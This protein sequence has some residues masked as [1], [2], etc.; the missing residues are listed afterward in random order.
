[1]K[2]FF[3]MLIV[4]M[5]IMIPVMADSYPHIYNVTLTSA[6]TEYSQTLPAWTTHVTIQCRSAYDVRMGVT[7]GKVAGS[8]APF[9]T[10]K[11]GTGYFD[12]NLKT[13]KTLYF[14][15]G[16][17]GVVIEIIDWGLDA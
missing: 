16:Q 3:K 10:I 6:N 17:A 1:M 14:A 11:S 5:A 2:K 4:V 8:T 7:T 13:N 15:S 12:Y 9:W